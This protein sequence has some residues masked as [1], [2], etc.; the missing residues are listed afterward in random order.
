MLLVSLPSIRT[1]DFI[2][3]PYVDLW[4]NSVALKR[5]HSRFNVVR[6]GVESCDPSRVAED[7]GLS[8][9]HR[10][11]SLPLLNGD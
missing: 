8:E 10:S 2:Q 3:M 4:K 5:L 9:I 7:G 6:I 11:S 1:P